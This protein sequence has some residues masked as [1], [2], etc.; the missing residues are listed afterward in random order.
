MPAKSRRSTSRRSTR[1]PSAASRTTRRRAASKPK[2]SKSKKSKSKSKSKS[3]YGGGG[4]SI[5][6]RIRR[7]FTGS[8]PNSAAA[9]PAPPSPSYAN[10]L[11]SGNTPSV[12]NQFRMGGPARTPPPP[13]P[14]RAPNYN[15]LNPSKRNLVQIT[16]YTPAQQLRSAENALQNALRN[17]SPDNIYLARN[18]IARLTQPPPPSYNNAQRTTNAQRTN[19]VLPPYSE[20]TDPELRARMERR[21]KM[22]AFYGP[23]GPPSSA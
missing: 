22:L 13:S 21:R 12:F 2:K 23:D 7:K 6:E 16:H 10:R 11:L 9:E 18:R 5:F 14:S 8:R 4:G 17:Q 1:R 19:N 15:T 3:K 20:P